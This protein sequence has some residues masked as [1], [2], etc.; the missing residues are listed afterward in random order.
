MKYLAYLLIVVF[1]CFSCKKKENIK[2]DYLKVS[3]NGRYLEDSNGKPFLYLGCTAWELFHRLNREEAVEYLQN[4]KEKGFT[5]IQAVVLSESDGLRTTNAY[6]EFALNDFNPE[7]PNEK[8]FE[9]ID[10]VVNKAE[11]LGLYIGMLPTWG[12]KVPNIIGGYGPIIFTPENARNYGEFLGKRYKDKPIIWILGGDRNVDSDTTYNIWKNMA[13]GLK[14]GDQG[15]HLISYHPR[16]VHSSSYWLHNEEWIDFNMYQ[17]AHFHRYQ[18]VYEN[19]MDDY[20]LLPVK[21]T[22]DAEPAYEDM[23]MEFWL[24]DWTSKK[25]RFAILTICLSKGIFTKM[26]F[27]PIMMCVYMPIGTYSRGLVDILMATMR[28]SRCLKKEVKLASPVYMI[29]AN[30]WIVRVPM[31]YAMCASFSKPGIFRN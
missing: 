2:H 4:R 24:F 9:H 7:K 3:K 27:S 5:V 17:T 16:G 18:K 1:F 26:D 22:M 14:A 20:S 12:D 6:G 25:R 31:I 19:A 30:Q 23:P 13:E 29:G 15:K 10:F 21:P 11:E 8:Y 28:F